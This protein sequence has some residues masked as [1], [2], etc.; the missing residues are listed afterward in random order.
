MITE[1]TTF[2]LCGHCGE[3]RPVH[4]RVCPLCSQAAGLAPSKMQIRQACLEIQ[5]EWPAVVEPRRRQG[6]VAWDG[7][8]RAREVT[9]GMRR[10][11]E[12]AD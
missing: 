5:L 9:D 2:N 12:Y 10:R 3:Q 1:G 7:I 11:T 8:V 4:G 6:H